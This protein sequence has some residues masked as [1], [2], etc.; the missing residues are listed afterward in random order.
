MG[1]SGA[2]LYGV[3]AAALGASL[4][5]NYYLSER[6]RSMEELARAAAEK[7]SVRKTGPAGKRVRK[8]VPDLPPPAAAP[9]LSAAGAGSKESAYQAKLPETPILFAG[10]EW[11][12]GAVVIRFETESNLVS[13]SAAV[14]PAIPLRQ[15]VSNKKLRLSGPFRP[16]TKYRVT[17]LSGA[18]NESGGKLEENAVAEI[19]IPDM[20]P[21]VNFATAGLYLPLNGKK[22]VLP[23]RTVNCEK[24]RAVVY[25][26]F[27]NNLNPYSI[28]EFPSDSRMF[29]VA[30]KEFT[31]KTPKNHE[32]FHELDLAGLIGGR[33]PGVYR[34]LLNSNEQYVFVTDMALQVAEDKQTGKLAV[35]VRSLS[36]GKPVAGAELT[37]MSYKNQIAASGRTD[38]NGSALLTYDPAW[39]KESD[40]TVAVTAR[41]AGDLSFFRLQRRSAREC[42]KT[43]DVLL[44][45]APRAFVFAERG[46]ARPG[47]QITASAFLRREQQGTFK[48]MPDTV[49]EFRLENPSNETVLSSSVKADAYGFAQTGF[50]VPETAP[51]GLYTISCRAA[52]GKDTCGETLIRVASF[53]PDR[54]KISG[55]DL[56]EKCG[57]GDALDFEFDA[58][59]YFGAPLE[60]GSYQYSVASLPAAAPGHWGNSWHAGAEDRF[61]RAR[62]FSGKGRKGP[63]SVKIHYPGFA[64]QKGVAFDPVNIVAS[65]EA[66]EPGGRSVTGRVVKK[67]YPTSFFI[68]V[69]EAESKGKEKR[70]EYTLLPAVKSDKVPV[71]EKFEVTFELARREW[72]YVLSRQGKRWKREWVRRVIPLPELKKTVLIP[73][74]DFAVGKVSPLGWNLPSGAYTLTAV[75][76]KNYRTELDFYWYAGEGGERSANPN[77]LYFSTDAERVAPGGTLAFS[78]DAPGS[79]E[80]FLVYG[81]RNLAGKRVVPVKPGRNTVKVTV[82]E[83]I[84]SSS[85]YV[86]CTV[87]TRRGGSFHR[88]FGLLKIN[89]DQTKVHRL[90]VGLEHAEKAEPESLFPVKVTLKD[91]SGKPVSGEVCLYAVDSGV[92]SLTDYQT[93]DIF[94]CFYGDIACPIAFYDMY[95]LLF[96][97]LRITPDGKVGGDGE[98]EALKLGKL[99]Q[100]HTARLIAPPVRVPASG[101]A[102]VTVKLPEHTGQMTFFAVA[103]SENAVGSSQ[104]SVVMRK[105]VTVRISAPRFIAP[106]D[107]AEL[108]LTVFNH[109]ADGADGTCTVTL[110]PVL[111]MA[112]NGSGEFAVKGVGKGKQRTLIVRV[113]AGEMFDSGKITARFSVGSAGAKDETF[114]TVRSVNPPQGVYRMALLKPGET[115][116]AA[117]GGDFIGKTAGTIRLSAS[118]ALAVKNALDWLNDYPHG[119]LEQTTAGAFPFISL[120][121]LAKVGLVDEAMAKTNQ[122]K[123]RGAYAK[124]LS[125]ALSDGSFAMWPGSTATWEEA[126]IFALHFI[127]KADRRGLI[128]LDASSRD[129]YTHWLTLRAVLADPR[130]RSFRAYAAYVLAVAGHHSFLS[131]A[132][133]IIE[134]AKKPDFAMF[135]AGAALVKG[136]YASL[137]APAMRNALAAGCWREEGVPTTFSDKACRL[138][139]ALY[140]LMDCAIPGEELPARLAVELAKSLRPDGAAWGTTQAN[141][142]A[143]LGLSAYAEKYPPMPGQAEITVGGKKEVKTF[144]GALALPARAGTTVVNRSGGMLIA[145]SKIT[146]VP[147]KV[148][149]GGPI[150]LFREYRNEKG[151][152]VTAV[153]HG[154]KVRV[155]I[156]FETPVPIDNLVIT[157]LLP[158]GLEIE[159]E[160]LATRAA[161]LPDTGK[162]DHGAFNPKRLEKRDDRFLVFGDTDAGKGEITYQT[163]AVIRGTFAIPPLHAEAM[164]QPDNRG[165]YSPAGRFT[166]E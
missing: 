115:W 44:A 77:S 66:A 129:R 21:E 26:A 43:A 64:A 131:A 136:G 135:L 156:R 40:S 37:V 141:A 22:L 82:P 166:V 123:V 45:G 27:E 83:N 79:G 30:N 78:F 73:A 69:R 8:A 89:V 102:S 48:P 3:L 46:I 146:G 128:S 28:G 70:F 25:K 12:D 7:K 98:G 94:G 122:H 133:N 110:P 15:S 144:S 116:T 145:E 65:F 91:A 152:P 157:D 76:G 149:S 103:S 51:T 162:T 18:E 16:G 119:C 124:L 114:V 84:H 54:I 72:E 132:R 20:K 38:E 56:T 140:I 42:L 9:G 87:V 151:E 134:G 109:E 148:S 147:R 165:L 158:A 6:V 106:G 101:E 4:A 47:E 50:T 1:K 13:A 5:G 53:V 117:A 52:G 113:R 105:P 142:W 68:G 36:T 39:D 160:L 24:V 81:E 159:D 29:L 10:A 92:L 150:W 97:E 90:G 99:K 80:A 163:R 153:R 93:P 35:F 104:R 31:F 63:G 121:A 60:N 108:S 23:F 95:G 32:V 96:E 107:E 137:G 62:T 118:P 155:R 57:I 88:G 139:M 34:V 161:T 164:Y 74:G 71:P 127:F 2:V 143:A 138:G 59:Y 85:F 154:D 58:K 19:A 125:M 67:L 86:G 33:K 11:D 126:T 14:E 41:K 75:S 49:L 17:V 130:W 55:K 112:G 120:P 61:V 111:K 100:K